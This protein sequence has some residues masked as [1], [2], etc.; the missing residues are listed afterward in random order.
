MIFIFWMEI[1]G[2][3]M[4]LLIITMNTTTLFGMTK[5][6]LRMMRCEVDSEYTFY[7]K[8]IDY[9]ELGY[10]SFEFSDGLE[11]L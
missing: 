4:R 8:K 7:Q 6:Q 9:K 5:L 10:L 1:L 2:F 11:F 3:H